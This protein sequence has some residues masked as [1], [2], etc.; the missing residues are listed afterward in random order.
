MSLRD[1]W[2]TLL[3]GLSQ[4]TRLIQLH[5]GT[6]ATDRVG[7]RP[8]LAERVDIHEAIGPGW[9]PQ[10]L[11]TF[12]PP[13][14]LR[15][16][17]HALSDDAD[18][19]LQALRCR[20]AQ[21]V[22]Q[23]RQAPRLWQG[24]VSQAERLGS[25]GGLTRYRLVILPWLAFASHARADRKF[26]NQ[27]V[28][29]I[30]DA[31]LS[32]Y[33]AEGSLA[34]SWRFD[35]QDPTAYPVRGDC[36]QYRESDLA[37]V[38]RLMREEGLFGWFEHR[39]Q[40]GLAEA[41]S[42]E[43]V[44]ADHN[45]ALRAADEPRV[46]YTQSSV[47]LGEDSIT[48]WHR[49]VH[50]RA[51]RV[52]LVSPDRRST[53]LRA[54]AQHASAEAG[55]TPH[56]AL[57]HSDL[58][59]IYAYPNVSHAEQLALRQM[60]AIDARREEFSAL[61][62]VR[63]TA[64]GQTFMLTDHPLHR[65]DDERR[66]RFVV[67]GAHHIARSN[68]PAELQS[69]ADAR[70]GSLWAP[71]GAVRRGNDGDEPVYRCYVHLQRAAVPVR[72]AVLD[73]RGEPDP[74]L[75]PRR[76]ARGVQ[77]AMVV[78]G[79]GPIDADRDHQVKVRHHWQ[80]GTQ[81]SHPL[82]PLAGG[83]N[84]PGA[85]G[86]STVMPVAEVVAGANWGS[87][88]IKRAQQEVV[89]GHLHGQVDRGVVLGSTYNGRGRT[90]AA[91]NEVLAGAAGATGNAPPWFPGETA[92]GRWPGH[93]HGPVMTGFQ[94]QA[95]ASSQAGGG[96]VN[97]FA[98][99]DSPDERRVE[100]GTSTAASRLQLGEL[101]H[102]KGNELLAR[103]GRGLSLET[104]A[105]GALRA[106]AGM[107]LSAHDKPGTANGGSQLDCSEPRQ[108]VARAADQINAFAQSAQKHNA[109]LTDD[110]DLLGAEASDARRQLPSER[111]LR[112]LGTSLGATDQRAMPGPSE[113][114]AVSIGGGGG[115]VSAWTRPDL[116]V[117]SPGG[118]CGITPTHTLM[119]TG[120]T[121][122]LVAADVQHL[123]H[124]EH[125]TSVAQGIV[126]FTVGKPAD[127]ADSVCGIRLHAAQGG[128]RSE[129]LNG[130]ARYVAAADVAVGSASGAVRVT[131]PKHVLLT[132]GGA[133]LQIDSSGITLK[134][135]GKIDFKASMKAFTGPASASAEV[136]L[137]KLGK[138]GICRYRLSGTPDGIDAE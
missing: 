56:P 110:P 65:G 79:G 33:R 71:R 13:A 134:G 10:A 21:V 2:Q 19:D 28:P 131:S 44:I 64:P 40:P 137:A 20:H 136:E 104:S 118:I 130:A 116:V 6:S 105:W 18:L 35:L 61:S 37:F 133:A 109:H 113:D 43:F 96:A 83:D 90:D 27:T 54:V 107:L 99:C 38:E 126:L 101:G 52:E 89:V 69:A 53:G 93:R 57:S 60:Q 48:R 26:K 55:E 46:R 39:G 3:G 75:L 51:G 86:F 92:A 11:S 80:R 82:P 98:F 9:Q 70:L 41:G 97:T 76:A 36:S 68:L 127:D 108:Q 32:R 47:A 91:G 81:A 7:G 31:V 62:T 85:A 67:L 73:R 128:F 15:L 111:S 22:L 24:H 120:E 17:V 112:Q 122:S 30:I 77:S 132:A 29:E 50:L 4:D 49:S 135:P 23:A 124:G 100:L 129:S 138:L 94:T 12:A 87:H 106:G 8:L 1:L 45:G 25:D 88:F 14:G 119:S 72:L 103:R 123:A 121:L 59:G 5:L 115:A 102:L 63:S 74:R 42:H 78:S 114:A 84:A 117:A 58:P 34:A 95:L 16:V 125:A 66:D